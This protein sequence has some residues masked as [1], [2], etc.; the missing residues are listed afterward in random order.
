MRSLGL[1]SQRWRF[2]PESQQATGCEV[3]SYEVL[4]SHVTWHSDL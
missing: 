1:E 4:W 3:L 2:E